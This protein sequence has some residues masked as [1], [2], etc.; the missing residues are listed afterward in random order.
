MKLASILLLIFLSGCTSAPFA[1]DV[2]ASGTMAH[3]SVRERPDYPFV[4]GVDGLLS[5]GTHAVPGGPARALWVSPGRHE[6]AYQCPGWV[7]VDGPPT[8][9]KR[10]KAGASYELTCESQPAI[11]QVR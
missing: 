5:V 10:F 8:L 9:M 4:P 3:L 11:E 2:P 6:I 1:L 7:S